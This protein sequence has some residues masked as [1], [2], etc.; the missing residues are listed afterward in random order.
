MKKYNVFYVISGIFY[1]IMFSV[2]F[3]C[4][5]A[6]GISMEAAL[7]IGAS[8]IIAI[9]FHLFAITSKQ[10]KRIDELEEIIKKIIKTDNNDDN[11][12]KWF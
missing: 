9:T 5:N 7:L 2:I 6:H 10:E 12:K 11:N 3:L 1:I 4:I 8:A